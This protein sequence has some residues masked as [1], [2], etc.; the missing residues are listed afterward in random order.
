MRSFVV[1]ALALLAAAPAGA[2][3]VFVSAAEHGRLL[4]SLPDGVF[5]DAEKVRAVFYRRDT[6]VPAYQRDGFFEAVARNPGPG[7]H[8]FGNAN[9]EFPWNTGG[10]DN[11]PNGSDF[12]V[13]VLPEGGRLT[14]GTARLDTTFGWMND[15]DVRWR[16]GQRPDGFSW[17]T[18]TFPVGAKVAEVIRVDGRWTCEVRVMEKVRGGNVVDVGKNWKF[19]WFRPVRDRAHLLGLTA[20]DPYWKSLDIH[21]K[22]PMPVERLRDDHPENRV[23]DVTAPVDE[24]PA[25]SAAVKEKLLSRPF[26][27]VTD[28][29][30]AESAAGLKTFAPRGGFMPDGFQGGHFSSKQCVA[31]HATVLKHA[32][33]FEIA[34]RRNKLTEWYGRV[35]GSDGVFSIP[36]ADD[37]AVTRDG[38]ARPFRANQAL[39]RAGLLK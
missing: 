23:L 27:E 34:D 38:W 20:G 35:R 22:R 21:Y 9:R 7:T 2:A 30:W 29:P 19:R 33:D 6:V 1:I 5:T 12:K 28:H 17:H 31:C 15:G 14:L 37:S 26:A 32:A 36:F 13:L 39:S 3:P 18:C 25:M 24:L 4:R 8:R 10:L 11:S 16:R